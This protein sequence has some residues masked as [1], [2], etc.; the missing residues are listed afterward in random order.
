MKFTALIPVLFLVACQMPDAGSVPED[1]CGA[2]AYQNL[3][4]APTAAAENASAPGPV[5]TFR[6]GQ[7]I[8]MDYRLDRLNFELDERDRIIRVF[9]G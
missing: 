1:A 4:G 8:T 3:V 2:S 5:R 9:C 6:S 7:P